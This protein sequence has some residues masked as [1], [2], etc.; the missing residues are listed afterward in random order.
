MKKPWWVRL[1]GWFFWFGVGWMV[2]LVCG[3]ATHMPGAAGL[4]LIGLPLYVSFCAAC[5]VVWMVGSL[6]A[7]AINKNA[8]QQAAILRELLPRKPEPAS[9][10]IADLPLRPSAP[11]SGRATCQACGQRAAE[12]FC[13]VHGVPLCVADLNAHDS[14]QCVY[15]PCSRVSVVSS[16]STKSQRRSASSVLGL[17]DTE[18][19]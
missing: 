15:V 4:L 8:R 9:S 11:Q 16:G 12:F 5:L 2:L 7:W 10:L 14:P 18:I 17:L 3:A 1:A 19:R 13:T 6:V